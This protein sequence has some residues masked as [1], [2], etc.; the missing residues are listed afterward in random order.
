MSNRKRVLFLILIMDP[1]IDGLDTYRQILKL[2]PN[3]KAIIASGFSETQ[4]VK[5]AQKL[6]A[7]QY[8]KKPYTLE[9]LGMA[10]KKELGK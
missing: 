6:G 9:K 8:V 4:R 5:A 10:V 7:G 1:G 3:L 2:H